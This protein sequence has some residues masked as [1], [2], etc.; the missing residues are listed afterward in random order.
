MEHDELV[1]FSRRFFVESSA[2]LPAGTPPVDGS[3]AQYTGGEVRVRLMIDNWGFTLI[4]TKKCMYNV[5]F[6]QCARVAL[7]F[8]NSALVDI[9]VLQ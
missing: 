5:E 9:L 6:E 1:G 3:R 4:I 7:S 8:F 2:A